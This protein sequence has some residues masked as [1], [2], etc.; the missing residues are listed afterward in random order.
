MIIP[1]YNQAGF[2][3]D[4]IESV[5]AQTHAAREVIVVDD[6]S[7]DA[8]S[9]VAGRYPGVRCLRQ[10]KQGVSAARNAGLRAATGIYVIFLDADDRLLPNAL[11]DG[12]EYLR[13]HPACGFVYGHVRL[14]E[15][16][17]SPVP[18]PEAASD[19]NGASAYP[20][21]DSYID[22]LR[23]NFIWTPGAVMYRRDVFRSTLAFNG[24]YTPCDDYELN[25]RIA[26]Q[27]AIA[28]HEQVVLEYRQHSA[29][30]SADRI[31][32]LRGAITVWRLQ[33]RTVRGSA[34]HEAAVLE[35]IRGV[36]MDYGE[37]VVHGVRTD[38]R[39][40]RWADAR[41]GILTLLRYYPGGLR[42]LLDQRRS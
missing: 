17:G 7:T 39:E 20:A 22:L 35:G 21:N 13:A 9:V 4:A 28:C 11:A 26:R 40:R 37:Q 30:M 23:G 34:A 24:T 27:F 14:I 6:G 16:D 10:P 19:G 1:C 25:C 12:A 18:A 32:M 41:R 31:E 3:A 2:L 38:L 15:A 36:Q 42:R 5:L 8:T 33:R 29:K